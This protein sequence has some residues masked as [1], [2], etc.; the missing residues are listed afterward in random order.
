MCYCGDQI[1]INQA[2]PTYICYFGRKAKHTRFTKWYMMS[3]FEKETMKMLSQLNY[4]YYYMVVRCRRICKCTFVAFHNAQK[5]VKVNT[6]IYLQSTRRACCSCI[7]F[8]ELPAWAKKATYIIL[9]NPRLDNP[10]VMMIAIKNY[11]ILC[12]ILSPQKLSCCA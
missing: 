8:Y 10:S 11:P 12:G 2:L 7:R 5:F 3:W 1:L 6:D 4:Y 9:W